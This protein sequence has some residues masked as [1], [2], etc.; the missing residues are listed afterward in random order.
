MSGLQT[1]IAVFGGKE[2]R[3]RKLYSLTYGELRTIYFRS[4][5]MTILWGILILG[6]VITLVVIVGRHSETNS[7]ADTNTTSIVEN[8]K[9]YTGIGEAKDIERKSW[10]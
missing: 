7:A 6:L 4:L 1:F 2:F 5:K 8:E 3:D 9:T 10:K